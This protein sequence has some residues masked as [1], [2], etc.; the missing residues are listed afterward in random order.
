MAFAP[1][2]GRIENE[3]LPRVS[4]NRRNIGKSR[5]GVYEYLVGTKNLTSNLL[6]TLGVVIFIFFADMQN[7]A[8]ALR[9]YTLVFRLGIAQAI[10][11]RRRG[12]IPASVRVGAE[13]CS[14]EVQVLL[15]RP[16]GLV[17]VWRSTV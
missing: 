12:L 11:L 10:G 4:P 17:R 6:V 1:H 5:L 16:L 9:S 14:S 8:F 15:V 13:T 3:S 7:R 2:R